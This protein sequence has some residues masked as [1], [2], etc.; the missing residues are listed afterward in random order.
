MLFV[1]ETLHIW[2]DVVRN[3]NSICTSGVLAGKLYSN[4][5]GKSTVNCNLLQLHVLFPDTFC[6]IAVIP[7]NVEATVEANSLRYFIAGIC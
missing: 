5:T 7:V 4:A 1:V 3:M 2:G 6:P